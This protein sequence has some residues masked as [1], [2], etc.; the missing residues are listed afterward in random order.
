MT[1]Y[2]GSLSPAATGLQ[3][4]GK[5]RGLPLKNTLVNERRI[6]SFLLQ[7]FDGRAPPWTHELERIKR[8]E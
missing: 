7:I 5:R 3:T 4:L 8:I 2:S 6:E 1:I